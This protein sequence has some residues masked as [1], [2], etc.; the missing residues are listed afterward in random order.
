MKQQGR[1]VEENSGQNALD[2]LGVGGA[3]VGLR[4]HERGGTENNNNENNVAEESH[5]LNVGEHDY[6]TKK[7]FAKV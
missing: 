1:E 2:A 6:K 7:T 4:E 5:D 3:A